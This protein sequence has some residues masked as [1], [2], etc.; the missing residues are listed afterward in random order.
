MKPILLKLTRL[1]LHSCLDRKSVF[2]KIYQ[3]K[4]TNKI[5]WQKH[6]SGG[7]VPCTI[8]TLLYRNVTKITAQSALSIQLDLQ[9]NLKKK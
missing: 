6:F 8:G 5:C 7:K 4:I 1:I 2:V 9:F 3:T